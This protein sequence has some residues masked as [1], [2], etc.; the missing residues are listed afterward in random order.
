MKCSVCGK[1]G[2][3]L[4]YHYKN[5]KSIEFVECRCEKHFNLDLKSKKNDRKSIRNMRK[6]KNKK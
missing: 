4:L 2:S 6:V 1:E 5:N 3:Y